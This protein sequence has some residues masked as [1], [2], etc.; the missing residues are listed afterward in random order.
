MVHRLAH[1]THSNRPIATA[2]WAQPM[3]VLQL[4]RQPTRHLLLIKGWSVTMISDSILAVLNMVMLHYHGID[5][6]RWPAHV[7]T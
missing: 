5:K 3:G 1:Q 7:H 4:P 6:Y 2:Q